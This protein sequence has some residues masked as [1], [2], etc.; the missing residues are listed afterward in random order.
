[1]RAF[2]L[3]FGYLSIYVCIKIEFLSLFPRKL[4]QLESWN[5]EYNFMATVS[6]ASS[7]MSYERSEITRSELTLYKIMI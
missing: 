5:L 4:L 1:M 2:F 3:V 6:N 7:K